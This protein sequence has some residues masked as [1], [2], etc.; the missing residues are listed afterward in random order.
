M[1]LN[2]IISEKI[3]IYNCCFEIK[4]KK[5]YSDIQYFSEV[6]IN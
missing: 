1:T 2:I 3:L 4:L 6:M 5:L